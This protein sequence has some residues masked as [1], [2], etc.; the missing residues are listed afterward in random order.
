MRI[1]KDPICLA[2]A[3][4]N[5]NK[6]QVNITH[7]QAPRRYRDCLHFRRIWS[8]CSRPWSEISIYHS[9]WVICVSATSPRFLTPEEQRR[10]WLYVFR[11]MC[12]ISLLC[13]CARA[14]H[15]TGTRLSDRFF[16]AVNL[17][18]YSCTRS[19]ACTRQEEKTYTV[20][21]HF[22]LQRILP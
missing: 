9:T 14:M 11:H 3:T 16:T 15:V 6:I 7:T 1:S 10:W 2:L 21:S 22:R 4:K 5:A 20:V 13:A 18:I 17:S 12:F 19:H 8:P